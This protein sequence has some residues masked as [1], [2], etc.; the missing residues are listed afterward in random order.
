MASSILGP[1]GKPAIPD[2]LCPYCGKTAKV[3]RWLDREVPPDS[4]IIFRIFYCG[5]GGCNKLFSITLLGQKEGLVSGVSAQLPR[6][7]NPTKLQG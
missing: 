4:G 3:I 7:F 2:P 5:W 6:N 1:T